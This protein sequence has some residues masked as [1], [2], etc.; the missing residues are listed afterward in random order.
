VSTCFYTARVNL[1]QTRLNFDWENAAQLLALT[2]EVQAGWKRLVDVSLRLS[3]M[4]SQQVSKALLSGKRTQVLAWPMN[5]A[6][7]SMRD[8]DAHL[9][10]SSSFRPTESALIDELKSIIIG[11]L[12]WVNAEHRRTWSKRKRILCSALKVGSALD[13]F[14]PLRLYLTF[15]LFTWRVRRRLSWRSKSQTSNARSATKSSS[16][17][18]YAQRGNVKRTIITGLTKCSHNPFGAGRGL[19]RQS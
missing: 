8:Q 13:Y 11:C 7:E 15:W 6:Q 10:S 1:S 4:P 19:L 5:V 14:V 3:A 18:R 12:A 17:A 2:N 16:I 9:T